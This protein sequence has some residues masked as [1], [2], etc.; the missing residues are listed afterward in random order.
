VTQKPSCDPAITINC[1]HYHNKRFDQTQTRLTL[2]L[3][4]RRLPRLLVTVALACSVGLHWSLLQSVAWTTML[5]G[6]LQSFSVSEA[7]TRTFDGKHPCSLCK[8]VAAGKKSQEKP[9]TILSLKKFDG[10]QPTSNL[11]I[12]P[13]AAFPQVAELAAY[14]ESLPHAPP[15]PPPR[16][17]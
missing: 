16:S 10:L 9:N 4:F 15:F 1:P 11:A 14:H 13:P 6:N 7:V 8:A 12:I 5:V 17:V 3:V 2:S